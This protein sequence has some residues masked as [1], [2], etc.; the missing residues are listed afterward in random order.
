LE[1][2]GGG[3]GVVGERIEEGVAKKKLNR[4]RQNKHSMDRA[5]GAEA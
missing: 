3:G 4:Q 1:A 2:N 5:M